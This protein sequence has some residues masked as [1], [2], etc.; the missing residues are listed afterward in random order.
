MK[1]ENGRSML[2][3]IGCWLLAIAFFSGC[4]G[5]QAMPGM[6][7]QIDANAA[8]AESVPASQPADAA[9]ERLAANAAVFDSYWRAATVN[10]LV[11]VLDKTRPIFCSPTF[12]GDLQ[13][14]AAHSAEIAR[15]AGLPADDPLRL[16]DADALRYAQVERAWLVQV[17]KN[18]DAKK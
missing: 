2:L 13:N 17:K 10:W 8:A 16:A 3:P 7:R 18:K 11:Y 12:Y 1:N 15:R 5:L 4:S 6:A 14:F 9:R